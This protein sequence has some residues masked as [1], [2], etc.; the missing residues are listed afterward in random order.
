V[1]VELVEALAALLPTGARVFLQVRG[2]GPPVSLNADQTTH[3]R[4]IEPPQ[5]DVLEVAEAMRDQF[6]RD[7]ASHFR[8]AEAHGAEAAAAAT[9]AEAEEE[10]EED[11]WASQWAARGWLQHNPM[12]VPTEREVYVLAGDLP[13]YRVLLERY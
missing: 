11:G 13:V 6:E 3:T 7:G 1:Q 10:E 8:V 9:A 5:S 4:M 2:V 12:G